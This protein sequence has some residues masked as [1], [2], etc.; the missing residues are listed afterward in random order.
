L[1]SWQYLTWPFFS[2]YTGPRTKE[3]VIEIPT[4]D[5]DLIRSI[6]P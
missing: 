2:K 4:D 5:P 1:L 3:I 6:S